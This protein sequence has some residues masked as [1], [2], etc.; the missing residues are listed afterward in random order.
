[1]RGSW[2]V[3]LGY[4]TS[5]YSQ[6]LLVHPYKTVRELARERVLG[7]LVVLPAIYW[8]L[9]WV[10]ACVVLWLHQ[11]LGLP[12]V[13]HVVKTGVV[14]G[15]WWVSIF[16]VLWQIVLLYLWRRFSRVI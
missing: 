5:A 6:G 1:M 13:W 12:P 11:V 15:F 9:A 16:L 3:T 10:T 7:P 4:W 14:F 2:I 8:I